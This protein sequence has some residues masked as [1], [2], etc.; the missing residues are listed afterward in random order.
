MELLQSAVRWVYPPQCSSCDRPTADDF[1][2]CGACWGQLGVIL[3]AACSMCGA[4]LVGDEESGTLVCD[5]CLVHPRPWQRGTAALRYENLGRKLVLALKYSDRTEIARSVAGLLVQK[6]DQLCVEDPILVPIPLHRK[7]LW[8]RR[9]NQSALLV[10]E[11]Q[12]RTACEIALRALRRV[13]PTPTLKEMSDD[14]RFE[15]LIGAITVSDVY[16]DRIK[17]RTIVVVDDVMTSGATFSAATDALTAS[18]AK[19]VY[20]LALARAAKNA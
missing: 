11:I 9:Y 12:K 10:Q 19:E 1:G 2:F 3:G 6:L 20:V 13:R 17:G 15:S 8:S 5:A 18:G 7:R 4:A 14:Q 16:K